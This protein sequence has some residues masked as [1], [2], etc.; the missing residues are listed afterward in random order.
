MGNRR[1]ISFD[2]QLKDSVI[3]EYSHLE[4]SFL[5][6]TDH[7]PLA[8]NMRFRNYKISSLR[9]A[10]F[11][12]SCCTWLETLFEEL[13]LDIKLD[14]CKGID[15]IRKKGDRTIPVYRSV[16]EKELNFSK[17]YCELKYFSG[18]RIRPYKKWKN[19]ESPDWWK[20][21]SK[22]KHRRFALAEKFT[23]GHALESFAALSIVVAIWIPLDNPWRSEL[24]SRVFALLR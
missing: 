11:G 18:S 19:G 6:L 15:R 2:Q 21:Y 20:L 12:V 17:R 7:I 4:S 13:L 5:E 23:M 1:S 24:N 3:Q 10:D 14:K 9:T 16:F 8:P 22:L